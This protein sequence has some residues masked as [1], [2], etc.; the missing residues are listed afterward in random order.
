MLE[1]VLNFEWSEKKQHGV[2]KSKVI[3]AFQE[4][5]QNESDWK[6]LTVAESRPNS[7]IRARKAADSL[8]T[9]ETRQWRG[10]GIYKDVQTYFT[11]IYGPQLC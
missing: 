1:P 9:V 4:N 2:G 8:P 5:N 7:S 10:R 3:Q 6:Q 11:I